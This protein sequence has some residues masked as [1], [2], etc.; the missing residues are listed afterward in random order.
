[1]DVISLGDVINNIYGKPEGVD[2][3]VLLKGYL[4]DKILGLMPAVVPLDEAKLEQVD[5]WQI[6]LGYIK[7]VVNN[8]YDINNFAGFDI[9]AATDTDINNVGT[10]LNDAL[11]SFLVSDYVANEMINVLAAQD[12]DKDVNEIKAVSDWVEE[13]ELIKEMLEMDENS[14]VTDIEN[15]FIKIENS[16]LLSSEKER[17]LVEIANKI[18]PNIP[19]STTLNAQEYIDEKAMLIKM[20]EFK[21][22]LDTLI[23]PGFDFATAD[24]TFISE[25]G[26]LIDDAATSKL[27]EAKVT[28]NLREALL[29][30]VVYTKTLGEVPSWGR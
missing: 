23:D 26:S 21:D 11:S 30:D 20:F 25:L 14:N 12:I 3:S 8:P 4:E 27:F 29:P 17:I 1:M 24:D 16:D 22:D 10:L 19:L 2:E 6:E 5:D 18:D 15:L 28:D 7:A 13:L 9:S